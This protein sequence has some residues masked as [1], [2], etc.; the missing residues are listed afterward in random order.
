[1]IGVAGGVKQYTLDADSRIA[2]YL[3]HSQNPTRA[4]NVVLKSEMAPATLTAAV[5]DVLRGLDPDLPMYNV[6]TMDARVAESLARRRF[7]MQLLTLFA[8]VAL[9]LA[10]IGIYGVMAYLVSQGRRE[11]G[12][13]VALGATPRSILSLIARQTAAIAVVGVSIGIAAALGLSRFM[14][15][16]LFDVDAADPLTFVVIGLF[17]GAVA[18]LAGY[19]PARRA[20]RIDPVVALRAE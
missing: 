17:L 20:S 5:R 9:G 10:T 2:M 12:I 16:L 19:V 15:S 4:M 8:T 11:L 18:M 1:V 14:Q 7:A 6:R 13:R 3:P